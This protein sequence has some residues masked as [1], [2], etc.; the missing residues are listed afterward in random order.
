MLDGSVTSSAGKAVSGPYSATLRNLHLAI[1]CF[2][3]VLAI[4]GFTIYF[5]E[6]LGA[7]AL[8]IPLVYFH[9]ITAYLFLATLAVR[10]VLGLR[11]SESLKLERTFP[12]KGDLH[13]LFAEIKG[14]KPIKFAGRSPFSRTIAALIYV[15]LA[16]NAATGMVR[17]GTDLYFPPF[18]PFVRGYVA[19]DGADAA[20]V[21]PFERTHVDEKRFSAVSRSKIPFGRAHIYGGF[22]IVFIALVHGVGV[23]STEWSAPNDPGARG[24]ARLMLFGPRREERAR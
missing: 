3:I 9:A 2:V 21:R 6:P 22:L 4:S 17:A 24:R 15:A 16:A 5:R 10:I 23:L 20:L 19:K 1:A 8:K 13:R 11:G 14:R 18:G 7:K 12:R